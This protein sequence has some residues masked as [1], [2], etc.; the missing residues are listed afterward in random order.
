M[1]KLRM[2][3]AIFHGIYT[4]TSSHS[5]HHFHLQKVYRQPRPKGSFYSIF[6]EKIVFHAPGN[7][8]AYR[9][10]ISLQEGSLKLLMTI[11][12]LTSRLA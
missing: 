4:I 1:P 2:N 11:V 6:C 7:N 3:D 10:V 12:A 9:L 5:T 8:N